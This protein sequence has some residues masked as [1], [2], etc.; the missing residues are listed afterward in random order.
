MISFGLVVATN[1]LLA[2]KNVTVT[3]TNYKIFE[4]PSLL[5]K[6]LMPKAQA[7]LNKQAIKNF[8]DIV[9]EVKKAEINIG[10]NDCTTG[11]FTILYI[12]REYTLGKMIIHGATE[13]FQII[14]HTELEFEKLK[15]PNSD[16][17]YK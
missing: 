7:W 3:L 8:L 5:E 2:L 14:S 11:M 13:L 9:E 17:S 6:W 16:A 12:A 15:K 10:L 1:N 4:K